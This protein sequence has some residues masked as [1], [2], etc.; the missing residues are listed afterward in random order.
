MGDPR[1][2][3][4][5]DAYKQAEK[6]EPET[7]EPEPNTFDP[8]DFEVRPLGHNDSRFFYYSTEKSMVVALTAGNHKALEL[9]GMANKEYWW[10]LSM[11]GNAGARPDK[12]PWQDLASMLMTRC[13]HI[14]Y[15]NPD[16]IRGRGAWYDRGR[17]VFN[18]GDRLIVDG[19][20]EHLSAV[21]SEFIYTRRRPMKDIDLRRTLA[22]LEARKIVGLAGRFRWRSPLHGRLLAGWV[23]HSVICGASDWRAHIWLTGSSGAGKST[24]ATSFLHPLLG[25]DCAEFFQSAE[26]TEAGIRQ[27]MGSDAVPIV[28]DEFEADSKV[29]QAK[30]ERVLSLMRQA[31]RET[32]GKIIKGTAVG[33]ASYYSMRSA[34]CIVSIGVGLKHQADK[35]RMTVLTLDGPGTADTPGATK[36]QERWKALS[37]DLVQTLTP[38]FCRSF[39]ARMIGLIPA[40]RL[41][42]AKISTVLRSLL[43]NARAADQLGTLLTGYW[44]LTTTRP[45]TDE[46]AARLVS[47]WQADLEE[48]QVDANLQSDETQV[49][50]HIWTSMIAIE[51]N[52][53]RTYHRRVSELAAIVAGTREDDSVNENRA[54]LN[55]RRHGLRVVP[56]YKEWDRTWSMMISTDQ[57]ISRLM[58]NTPWAEGWF[59]QLQR[60]EG[61]VMK[62]ARFANSTKGVRRC[63]AIP[64]ADLLK[65]DQDAVE[66]G[67]EQRKRADL[68]YL[69]DLDA[70]GDE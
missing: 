3:S 12:V 43:G 53:G 10:F 68:L 31:S 51:G 13:R 66:E 25:G 7:D 15:F 28:F 9:I 16:N 30:I 41:T 17:S 50:N 64:L 65:D 45:I 19:V 52:D 38:E 5:A 58:A 55:L 61:A 4:I 63:I 33:D 49:L 67:S 22:D 44:L 34:F 42:Q 69:E 2:I 36:E 26:T 32:S 62:T 46:Q 18:V 54:D 39:R 8:K 59:R 70:V 1:V 48:T 29:V 40:F 6:V 47:H 14:G 35:S 60:V 57:Q 56:I 20:Q 27:H 37:G 11:M 23:G 21:D 24:I